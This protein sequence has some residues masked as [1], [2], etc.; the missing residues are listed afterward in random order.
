MIVE[1]TE[2]LREDGEPKEQGTVSTID[3]AARLLQALAS[4]GPEGAAL[5][6]VARRTELGKA[7]VHRLLSALVAIGFAF[8]DTTSRRYRLGSRLG[9][10]AHAAHQH[11]VV[12]LARPVLAQIARATGDTV[13][14]SV[15]EGIAAVCVARELGSFPIRTLSLDVGHR[16]PLGIGSGS[17]A[18]LAFLPDREIEVVLAR[19]RRWLED[20]PQFGGE[21]LW[22]LIAETRR[23]GFSFIDGGIVPGMNA[24]GVPVLDRQRRP[25]AALSLAAIADRVSGDRITQLAQLLQQGA[26][27]L[28]AALTLTDG[29]QAAPDRPRTE[30]RTSRPAHGATARQARK[31]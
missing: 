24:I 30:R 7:T 20:Y 21:E 16:R 2:T 8:Q 13:Y 18:L 31:A 23:Y 1:Q 19:N 3:R 22:R 11:E 9:A 6:D 17:L 27:D 26:A 5:T 15:R 25:L 10:L 4:F 29:A 28:A 12:A 14:A